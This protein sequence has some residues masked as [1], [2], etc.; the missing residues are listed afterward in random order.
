MKT[1]IA[2]PAVPPVEPF[3]VDINECARRIG[4][5]KWSVRKLVWAKSIR[6]TKC[7]RKYL[8]A[9]EEIRLL[10]EKLRDGRVDFPSEHSRNK[11]KRVRQ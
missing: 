8:F 10:A 2:V 6:V 11:S 9:T 3:F 4:C 5:K 7:G 1:A